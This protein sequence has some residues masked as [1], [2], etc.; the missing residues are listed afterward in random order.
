MKGIYKSE[1][2]KEEVLLEYRNYLHEWPVKNEQYHIDT[3]FGKTFVIESGMKGKPVLLLLHGSVSNSLTWLGDVA[4]YSETHNVY[5][6]DIIGE[7]GFSDEGRPDYKSGDYEKW[8]LEIVDQIGADQVSLCGI[9]LGGWLSLNFAVHYPKRVKSMSLLCTSGLY[10]EKVSFIFKVFFYS[11]L[12]QWG[13]DQIIKLVNGGKAPEILDEG[14][15]KAMDFMMLIND[16][17]NP[18]LGAIPIFTEDQLTSLDM[19]IQV[20]YGDH[21]YLLNAEESIKRIKD[22]AKAVAVLL[23]KDTGHAVA[24]QGKV[25]DVFLNGH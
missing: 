18:R 14:M 3:S 6:I 11:L 13:K 16:N 2:G 23:L 17:F 5:C 8:L 15:K 12:G 25:V 19:P 20:I 21:D 1:K 24:N 4:L 9:S 22:H 7:A 10:R